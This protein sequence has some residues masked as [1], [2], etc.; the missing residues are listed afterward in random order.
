MSYEKLLQGI[1]LSIKD[2]F[3]I[4]SGSC[5]S[6]FALCPQELTVKAMYR[7]ERI[8]D[9]KSKTRK[10]I[11]V[12]GI[13]DDSQTIHAFRWAAIAKEIL[14][15]PESSD[16]YLFI[17]FNQSVPLEVCLRIESTEQFCR[18]Y[19]IHP[20][21]TIEH[22]MERTFLAKLNS[23]SQG[24]LSADPL[25]KSFVSVQIEHD[26]FNTDEQNKWKGIL[27]SGLTGSELIE[28]LFNL[29]KGENETPEE[30]ND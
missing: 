19:V 7:L 12:V 15:D 26:W 28:E 18:K 4:D 2:R 8:T 1:N 21:E 14:I 16:L 3:N 17:C 22:F 23:A 10:T 24:I 6:I 25:I 5:E 13:E 27:L 29:N 11:L 20:E 9:P 30:N